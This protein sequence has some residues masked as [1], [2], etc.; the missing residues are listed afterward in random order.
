MIMAGINEGIVE[1][2]LNLNLNV[3]RPE[4]FD[5]GF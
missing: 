1:F 5:Q 4:L 3:H 2:N